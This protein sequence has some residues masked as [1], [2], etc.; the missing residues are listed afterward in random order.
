MFRLVLQ[1]IDIRRS[2]KIN[3]LEFEL[4]PVN[5]EKRCCVRVIKLN[6]KLNL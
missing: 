4:Q 1:K 2:V 5:F 3:H 6:V